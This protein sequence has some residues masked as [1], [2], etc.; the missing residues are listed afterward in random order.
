MKFFYSEFISEHMMFN[1]AWTYHTRRLECLTASQRIWLLC[2]REARPE[3]DK[4]F[5]RTW[6]A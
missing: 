1:H 5:L 2:L 3:F 6:N 4:Q